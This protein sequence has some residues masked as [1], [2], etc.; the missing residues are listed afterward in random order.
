MSGHIKNFQLAYESRPTRGRKTEANRSLL[1]EINV[2]KIFSRTNKAGSF[3]QKESKETAESE[4]RREQEREGEKLMVVSKLRNTS[5]V[6]AMEG[7]M[8]NFK[9]NRQRIKAFASDLAFRNQRSEKSIKSL[10]GQH[11]LS[12]AKSTQKMQRSTL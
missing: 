6:V 1:R 11:L 12:C 8:K 5:Q 10:S 3:S 7:L 4:Q 9:L 2:L